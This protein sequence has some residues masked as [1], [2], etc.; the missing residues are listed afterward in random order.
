MVMADVG[1]PGTQLYRCITGGNWS[2][3]VIAARD[4]F[5]VNTVGTGPRIKLAVCVKPTDTPFRTAVACVE[6][7]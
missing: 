6:L 7:A 1:S 3:A 5:N 2:K 4:T